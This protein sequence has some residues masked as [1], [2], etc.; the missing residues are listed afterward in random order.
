M[1]DQIRVSLN[2]LIDHAGQAVELGIPAITLFPATLPERKDSEAINPENLACKV[3]RFQKPA[4]P[5]L[6]I[7]GDV[8]LDPYTNLG[9]DGVLRN[10]LIT[11]DKSLE[12]LARQAVIQAQAGMDMLAPSVVMDGR[13]GVLRSALD[14]ACLQDVR[15][16]SDAAK[17]ASGFYGPFRDALGSSRALKDDKRTYQMDPANSVEALR[18]VALDLQEGA[19][20]AMI[21][22]GMPYLEI[23]QRVKATFATPTFAYQVSGEY[24]MIKGA[25]DKGWLDLDK[26]IIESLLAFKRAGSMAF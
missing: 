25:I 10:G 12:V 23:I 26:I 22:T 15:L 5:T 3:A 14:S 2:K 16:M 11:N 18:E 8:A 20:M 6:G 13:I 24:S 4:F 7:I 17:Y 21:N 19:D 9:H 1:P